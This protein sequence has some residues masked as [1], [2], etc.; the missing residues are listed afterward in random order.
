MFRVKVT[1]I[2]YTALVIWLSFTLALAGWVYFFSFQQVTRLKELSTAGDTEFLKYHRMLI[3]EGTVLFTSL[4]LGGLV[5][6]YYILRDV[7]QSRKIQ[8]FFLTFSHE[9]K[10][11]LASLQLQA[12]SLREDLGSSQHSVLVERL[13]SDANRLAIQ[14]ENSLYLAEDDKRHLLIEEV[15][16]KDVI[17][18]ACQYWPD[19]EVEVNGDLIV[20][21]D[22]R[23]LEC[24]VKN[25]IQNSVIHGK[26]TKINVDMKFLSDQATDNKI[27][28]I[29]LLDNGIGFD[30]Q[31][32]ELGKMFSRHYSGSGNGVGLYLSK[33]LIQKMNGTI[34]FSKQKPNFSVTIQLPGTKV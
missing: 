21:S 20:A 5:I 27:I 14:L 6:G 2:K 29:I 4:I 16:V 18:S 9:L 13:V 7:R 17:L 11:P 19:L 31:G 34:K 23:A 3:S 33:S 8:N 24:V 15:S 30:G 1:F 32:D 10:T 12:E 22:L 26:A 28:E 25:I